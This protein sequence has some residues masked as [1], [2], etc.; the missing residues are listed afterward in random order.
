MLY[1]F[2]MSSRIDSL[3]SDIQAAL[4]QL[5][6]S[7]EIA[8]KRRRLRQSD[9][10][11]RLGISRPTL[12]RL[13][14]GDPGVRLATLIGALWQYGLLDDITQSLSPDRDHVGLALEQSRLPSSVRLSGKTELSD[15]F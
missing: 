9:V 3:P 4:V 13:E 8:R 11:E 14:S 15:D 2:I 6:R 10:A 12:D 1:I 5:G 7:L